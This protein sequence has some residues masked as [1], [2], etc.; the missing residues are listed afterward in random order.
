MKRAWL[1]DYTWEFVTAQNFLLCE[2]KSALH[3]PTSDGHATTRSLWAEN[4]LREMTLDE[5][6]KLCGFATAAR[7]FVFT[8]GILS[9]RSS[10]M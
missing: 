7:L 1:R 4:Y 8:M 6:V 5:A 10:V 2:A 9:R 3:K